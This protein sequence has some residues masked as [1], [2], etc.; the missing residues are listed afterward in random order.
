MTYIRYKQELINI[1]NIIYINVDIF[2]DRN[3]YCIDFFYQQNDECVVIIFE[4][5]QEIRKFLTTLEALIET[6]NFND[7]MQSEFELK[8]RAEQNLYEQARK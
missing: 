7:D 4:T 1:E 5:L 8:A 6:V 3:R 2:A